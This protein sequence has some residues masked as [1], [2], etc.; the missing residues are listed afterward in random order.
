MS[1]FDSRAQTINGESEPLCEDHVT[2]R[3][4]VTDQRR[5]TRQ[6]QNATEPHYNEASESVSQTRHYP[7]HDALPPAQ[8]CEKSAGVVSGGPMSTAAAM[9]TVIVSH[10][11]AENGDQKKSKVSCRMNKRTQEKVQMCGVWRILLYPELVPWAHDV[12][13]EDVDQLQESVFLNFES[14]LFIAR[15][16]RYRERSREPA[17]R[18]RSERDQSQRRGFHEVG[19]DAQGYGWKTRELC[20]LQFRRLVNR[21]GTTHK[22]TL[23]RLTA[24]VGNISSGGTRAR[25][26]GAE[27]QCFFAFDWRWASRSGVP[28]SSSG[29]LVREARPS[30]L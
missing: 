4:A 20:K 7:R 16:G 29:G 25:I 1:V 28:T 10:P 14:C 22:H 11:D 18:Q 24:G 2:W 19:R 5:P 8:L 17:E 21:T 27:P 6:L 26:L 12:P 3:T 30:L 13:R 9:V 15:Y 23:P